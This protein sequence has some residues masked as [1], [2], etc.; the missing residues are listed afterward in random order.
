MKGFHRRQ[1]LHVA[2]GVAALPFADSGE[3]SL[4]RDRVHARTLPP[5]RAGAAV[6]RARR[7]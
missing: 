2:A 6:L 7:A 5:A 4:A 3:A 1:F